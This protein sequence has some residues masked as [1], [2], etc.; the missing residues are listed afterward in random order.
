MSNFLDNLAARSLNSSGSIQPR[1]ASLFEPSRIA[2]R[3]AIEP[4]FDDAEEGTSEESLREY[5]SE[6]TRGNRSNLAQSEKPT[7]AMPSPLPSGDRLLKGSSNTNKGSANS[8]DHSRDQSISSHP[9]NSVTL[10]QP[11]LFNSQTKE[12]IAN[13][14]Q[15]QPPGPSTLQPELRMNAREQPR[16]SEAKTQNEARSGNEPDLRTIITPSLENSISTRQSSGAIDAARRSSSERRAVLIPST[17]AHNPDAQMSPASLRTRAQD[18]SPVIKITIGRIEV[19]ALMSSQTAP[20][21]VSKPKQQ[22][23]S[24]DEYL[25]QRSGG[26]R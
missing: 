1:V 7:S 15:K 20:R 6:I 18:S 17:A 8:L 14:E 5:V 10:P 12:N 4:T 25:K 13:E 24:L 9:Q 23:L 3:A 16:A 22:P 11:A 21:P 19:R 26:R 2:S